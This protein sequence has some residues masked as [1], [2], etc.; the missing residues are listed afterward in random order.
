M[1]DTSQ[2]RTDEIIQLVSFRLGQQEFGVDLLHVQGISHI[3]DVTT[4]AC[5]G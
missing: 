3:I 2:K 4:G 5:I 1:K